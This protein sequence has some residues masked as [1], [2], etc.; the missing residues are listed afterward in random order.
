MN[1]KGKIGTAI[2][3]APASNSVVSTDIPKCKTG[4][5][6][7]TKDEWMEKLQTTNWWKIQNG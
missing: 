1:Y 5:V 3:Y 7:K 2:S 4:I 6:G